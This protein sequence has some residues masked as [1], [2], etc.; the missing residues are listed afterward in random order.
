MPT[1]MPER[2]PVT[3]L[4]VTE[5]PTTPTPQTVRVAAIKGEFIIQIDRE[6]VRTYTGP[7]GDN[8]ET[9]NLKSAQVYKTQAG[10]QRWVDKH[11]ALVEVAMVLARG[12]AEV[13]TA[14]EE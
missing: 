1:G 10:A 5:L 6:G 12:E 9:P 4:P 14:T 7:G 8:W 3:E 2:E 11:P 13:A